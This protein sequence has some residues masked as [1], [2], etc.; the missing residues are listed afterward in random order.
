MNTY[1]T[2]WKGGIQIMFH[3]TP[4]M[5][6]EQHRRLIGNDICVLV[7][8]DDPT[9]KHSFQPDVIH[10][11]GTVPQ[12][13]ATVTP[14]STEPGQYRVGFFN[15]P[16]MKQ[17]PP[18][19]PP[20]D[21]SM[22]FLTTREY[23]FA[24]LYN[25]MHTSNHCPPLNRLFQ[26]PRAAAIEELGRRYPPKP[27]RELENSV[28]EVGPWLSVDI[29]NGK[30]IRSS[31][32][33]GLCNPYVTITFD[34]KDQKT[35]VQRKTNSPSW[36]ATVKFPTRSSRVEDLEPLIIKCWEWDRFA[37]DELIGTAKVSVAQ[38]QTASWVELK[39]AQGV[40]NGEIY[41]KI[42]IEAN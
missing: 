11:L 39:N 33:S 21:Y 18:L 8:F 41:I 26:V 28:K 36:D 23:L 31:R 42:A 37:T 30:D 35:P 32:S 20:M 3:M 17:Y 9:G 16:N 5:T 29:M 14:T 25:G 13:F 27:R 24:K 19:P 10:N 6:A 15:R 38:L 22:D 4:W 2:S 12:V 1:Y 7:Y 40:V 34:N